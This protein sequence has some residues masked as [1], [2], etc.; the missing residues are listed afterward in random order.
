MLNL[1]TIIPRLSYIYSNRQNEC[2][3]KTA[4]LCAAI[5][6]AIAAWH[7]SPAHA[8]GGASARSQT[9]TPAPDDSG[10]AIHAYSQRI[11]RAISDYDT[12]NWVRYW[13]SR[14]ACDDAS[15]HHATAA[16]PL[17]RILLTL[18]A[19]ICAQLDARL[20][21]NPAGY[22]PCSEERTVGLL[23][24]EPS[25]AEGYTLFT[26]IR[27]S[28]I[29]LLDPLGRVAHA[30][31]MNTS[32]F[33]AKLLD[34]G[35]LLSTALDSVFELD[36]RGEI[37]WQHKIDRLHHDFLKM[38]NGNALL[39]REETKTREQAIAAGANPEFVHE[40]G[41]EYDY[42]LEAR[43][44]GANGGEIV[45]EW[46]PWDHLIQDFDPTKPNYGAIAEHS[47]LININFPMKSL[48]I[49]LLDWTHA[50]T[51]D[52]NPALDQ[53]MVSPRH[54]SELWIIDH[55]AATAEARGHGGGNSGMGGD[56]LY[57]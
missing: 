28:D 51:I 47:E 8:D 57:R 42:L 1:I 36:P 44:T 9:A 6:L 48:Q 18:T 21:V 49:R 45:W 55:S 12:N 53:I 26:G 41:L 5:A 31:H 19:A 14:A 30:W 22:S 17:D 11:L 32:L 25:A 54:F 15:A 23:L 52:Y 4:T 24:N 38:P 29:F 13:Q 46:S 43:P 40:D 56:L 10:D 37:V 3:P 39:L 7:P 27:D 35:N 20:G 33:H 50:N 2:L 34:N 16:A